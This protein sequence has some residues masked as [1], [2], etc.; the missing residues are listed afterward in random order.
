MHCVK[1]APIIW[2]RLFWKKNQK[3][4]FFHELFISLSPIRIL[5]KTELSKMQPNICTSTLT[6]N[7]HGLTFLEFID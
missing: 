2:Q 1:D 6:V 4:N 3:L 5:V 7:L